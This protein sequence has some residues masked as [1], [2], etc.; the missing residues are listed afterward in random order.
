MIN[1]DPQRLRQL[2][3]NLFENSARYVEPDGLV[4][5]AL[6]AAPESVQITVE[7]SGPGVTTEELVQLFERFFRVER[8]RSRV[9]GGSGLGLSICRNIAE[10]HGGSIL[11]RH[12][13]HGG[14]AIR[15][16]LPR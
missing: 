10:A 14:L 13:E 7:D 9:G 8:G 11:A 1:A 3:H 16:E 4:R 12:S 15:I 2:L 6:T 5:V